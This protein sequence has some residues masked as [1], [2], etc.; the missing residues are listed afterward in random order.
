M[1]TI[2]NIWRFGQKLRKGCDTVARA[3]LTGF[4]ELDKLFEQLGKPEEFAFKAVNNAAPVLRKHIVKNLKNASNSK[5]LANSFVPT[6]AKVN[7]A[8]VYSVVRP[9]GNFNDDLSN[10]D[11]AAQFEY[12]RKG[13]YKR[14]EMKR[15]ATEMK[16]RPWR[17]RSI[18]DAR[19]ECEAIMEIEVLKAVDE[20]VNT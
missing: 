13:G 6:P 7:D 11:L 8:G 9:T 15:P 5:K 10:A 17:D 1:G 2:K 3:Q 16:P 19:K 14:H 4:D 18:N 12:G 20:A